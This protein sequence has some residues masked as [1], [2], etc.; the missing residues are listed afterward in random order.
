MAI[1]TTTTFSWNV[2]NLMHYPANG[3]IILAQGSLTG[4]ATG[5]G[6]VVYKETKDYSVGFSTDGISPDINYNGVT[7]TKV[8]EWVKEK[9]GIST[10]TQYQNEL[11]GK[12][13]T[14]ENQ[15]LDSSALPWS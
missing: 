13:D 4:I 5:P 15:G 11:K 7:E 2:T 1:S 14:R 3:L 12:I 8:L 6:G 10:I 9:I